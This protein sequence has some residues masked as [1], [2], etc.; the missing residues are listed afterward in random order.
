MLE[1]SCSP[2]KAADEVASK[3]VDFDKLWDFQDPAGTEAHFRALL[4]A[5]TTLGD[6]AYHHGLLTQLARAQGLGRKFTEA[7]A[8]LDSVEAELKSLP[9]VVRVRY[10]LE[11]GRVHNSSGDAAA[12]VPLF[13]AALEAARDAAEE[14]YAVDA[15]HML[16]IADPERSLTWNEQALSLAR[17]SQDPA[18]QNW[19]GSLY[20]NLGWTYHD[21]GEL[22]K[23]LEMFH[24]ALVWRE[25]K[26][27]S[28]EIR[29]AKWCV[30]RT[31]RSLDR[32]DEA[33][34][35]QVALK[36][37]HATAGTSDGFVHEE[38]A[39]C[40]LALGD[41][42]RARS[43]ARAAYEQLSLDPWLTANEPDRL[44]RLKR[45]AEGPEIETPPE[46]R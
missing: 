5:A 39:E 19:Q 17:S 46:P 9:A 36:A 15:A 30:A 44:A 29:V 10:L 8:T 24:A 2:S 4:P 33:L 21:R 27:E 6:P 43:Y 41:A 3:V 45:L 23:A 38:L 14:A 20:N 37:E 42:S 13:R 34:Q 16:A 22:A 18:A 28:H 12:A 11:R 40:C 31:L 1:E 35:M 32:L 7:H 26:Q 25:S